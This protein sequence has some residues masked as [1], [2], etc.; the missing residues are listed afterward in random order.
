M[1]ESDRFEVRLATRDEVDWALA[2]AASEGWNPGLDDAECF[3]ATDPEGLWVG[4][5]G[6]EPIACLS[7]VRYPPSFA[8]LGLHI[9]R[10]EYRARGYGR[11]LWHAVL[12]RFAGWRLGLEAAPDLQPAYCRSGFVEAWRNVR[13]RGVAQGRPSR[14]AVPLGTVSLDAIFAYDDAVFPVPRHDFLETWLDQ[15]DATALGMLGG[16]R[17]TGYGVVRPSLHGQRI[18]PLFAD[19]PAIAEEL[20]FA[21]A[22]AVHGQEISLDAPAANAPA[23]ALAAHA[24]LAP[25]SETVRMYR[26]GAPATPLDRVFG[27]TTLEL[28]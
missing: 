16:D 25:V 17:L 19:S 10:H 9:V 26:G 2:M 21:L 28:G 13:Y 12:P 7:A 24:G 27:V 20:Y 8:F 5:V 18:G 15:Y 6:D 22:A 1:V 4:L 11:L 14:Q 23:S 3:A